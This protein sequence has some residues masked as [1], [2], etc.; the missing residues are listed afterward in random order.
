M[1]TTLPF[2]LKHSLMDRFIALYLNN[3]NKSISQWIKNGL[4]D[5]EK[6]GLM[7]KRSEW[8]GRD[9]S[10]IHW[11][12]D[13]DDNKEEIREAIYLVFS[14][15]G[16]DREDEIDRYKAVSRIFNDIIRLAVNEK[17]SI[18]TFTKYKTYICSPDIAL[19]YM[20][21]KL[22][23]VEWTNVGNNQRR[24]LQ[25]KGEQPNDGRLE[26]ITFGNVANFIN[27]RI[28]KDGDKDGVTKVLC[29]LNQIRNQESH[30]A[31]Y[32]NPDK[33]WDRLVYMIYDYIAIAFF[34]MR[35]FRGA[36]KGETVDGENQEAVIQALRNA[37]SLI[38]EAENINVRFQFVKDAAKKQ[39]L[40]VKKI[41][42]ERTYNRS[43]NRN[44][45]S[46]PSQE[47][48][49]PYCYYDK[50][51]KRNATYA[52]QSVDATN[53]VDI[54]DGR[55]LRLKTSLLFDGAII[56][57][58]M[59]TE[60]GEITCPTIESVMSK[61]TGLIENLEDRNQLEKLLAQC[62]DDEAFR[63]KL[64][65]ILML[66]QGKRESIIQEFVGNGESVSKKTPD[67]FKTFIES[68][69]DHFLKTII[70]KYN[71]LEKKVETLN[72]SL[73]TKHEDLKAYIS[74]A[75]SQIDFSSILN[76]NAEIR[77]DL[78]C[79][80]EEIKNWNQI[81][82]KAIKKNAEEAKEMNEALS[83]EVKAAADS[84]KFEISQIS[85]ILQDQNDHWEPIIDGLTTIKSW[86][87][88]IIDFIKKLKKY[89]KWILIGV[90]VLAII[91]VSWYF[92]SKYI[93]YNIFHT[94]PCEWTADIAID[95][96]NKT[97]IQKYAE[98]LEQEGNITEAT[99]W[100]SRN[101][102]AMES[103]L[104]SSNNDDEIR[105]ASLALIEQYLY[106][107]GCYVNYK[108][109]LDCSTRLSGEEYNGLKSY[110]YAL[111]GNLNEA[112]HFEGDDSCS[113]LSSVVRYHKLHR[114]G[115]DK[116]GYFKFWLPETYLDG[117]NKIVAFE[118]TTKNYRSFLLYNEALIIKGKIAEMEGNLY[119][120]SL[121]YK[122]AA[123]QG[124][125]KGE[126]EQLRLLSEYA[127]TC[128]EEICN[129][130]GRIAERYPY[131]PIW[132]FL[133]VLDFN[134]Y[135]STNI[136]QLEVG[137]DYTKGNIGH[138]NRLVKTAFD[139]AK[140]LFD[141]DKP[142]IT[143]ETIDNSLAQAKHVNDSIIEATGYT[144]MPFDYKFMASKLQAQVGLRYL[145]TNSRLIEESDNLS[146]PV[147]PSFYKIYSSSNDSSYISENAQYLSLVNVIY[148]DSISR[149]LKT[150]VVS[151]L[152]NEANSRMTKPNY[153]DDIYILE[154]AKILASD[155]NIDSVS[156]GMKLIN[157]I[158]KNTSVYNIR[159]ECRK[160]RLKD[161][162][163]TPIT[164][165][166]LVQKAYE[167]AAENCGVRPSCILDTIKSTD[168][169]ERRILSVAKSLNV[170]TDYDILSILWS[171]ISILE[172]SKG[173]SFNRDKEQ[174]YHGLS[175]IGNKE[176]CGFM[177][178]LRMEN[179]IKCDVNYAKEIYGEIY[180]T[181]PDATFDY[182]VDLFTN[183]EYEVKK[184]PAPADNYIILSPYVP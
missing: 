44:V 49:N 174:F 89:S 43:R 72:N 111:N 114:E 141:S 119:E 124:C 33:Y 180:K 91:G 46:W 146:I 167:Y 53:G 34:L 87:K 30:S 8:F 79:L 129:S 14:I 10:D 106:G 42:E 157:S 63:N 152:R 148:S 182:L 21:Y 131:C 25:L 159:R 20:L 40:S 70:D 113:I 27:R 171:Y 73:Q 81:H 68:Q 115:Y 18:T 122:K 162:L 15:L 11:N 125:T 102:E 134:H 62:I 39:K 37:N 55:E 58:I 117:L 60:D 78:T 90:G 144:H 121:N 161:D 82:S 45:L 29:R 127:P 38:K 178:L 154:Y 24:V 173:S 52:I 109:A 5:G 32:T 6:D 177:A 103:L 105:Y 96:G 118:D 67:E 94:F 184:N 93:S 126:I 85:K 17:N 139:D 36:E 133:K 138:V 160:V 69:S 12:I 75:I 9:A 164:Y 175:L 142:F 107:K 59:P 57:L 3:G 168:I 120:A 54:Y 41:N 99:K 181:E 64:R 112:L 28:N 104:K 169:K 172:M 128:G 130:I 140:Y 48:G 98:K 136:L 76:S 110:L 176:F 51:L 147:L 135:K 19:Q 35:Y 86:V 47:D 116:N 23:Y 166:Q 132:M 100:W 158:F 150:R 179:A 13:V 95:C 2:D 155:N 26:N 153:A 143:V 84:T 149:Y 163:R 74:D 4:N 151:R 145:E 61:S 22:G 108:K 137:K 123:N 65:V 1:E 97:I 80:S 50:S 101:V 16:K 88:I 31:F 7:S 56:N 92:F 165:N 66:D 170:K 83:K 71:A 183:K 77:N 156:K